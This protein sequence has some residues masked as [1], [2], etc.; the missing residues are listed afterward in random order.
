MWIKNVNKGTILTG[1]TWYSVV[2]FC[3]MYPVNEPELGWNR[4][5]C[6]TVNSLN[7][8]YNTTSPE[9]YS[10]YFLHTLWRHQME[11]FSALL[12]ICAGN[13]PVTGE[14]PAQRPVTRSF[15]V[16]IDLR[17]NERLSK[18]W[19]G[20]WF[21][22]PLRPFWRHCNAFREIDLVTTRPGF[23]CI[24]IFSHQVE[25]KCASLNRG[26]VFIL[27]DGPTIFVWIGPQSSRTE[28]IKV[29]VDQS[30]ICGRR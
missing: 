12:V 1:S 30:H 14:F 4:P 29:G 25:L 5:D 16:F 10:V 11:T 2:I 23:I 15:D 27:D 13:S 18:Q 17:L 9:S 21:E 22:T 19:W 26:D 6:W 8:P 3:N 28:R 7:T 24:S 20:W